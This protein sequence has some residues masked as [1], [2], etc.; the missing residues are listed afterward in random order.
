[1]IDIKNLTKKFGGF[2]AISDINFQ[3][4]PCSVCGLIG[5]NGA[6]KTTLLKNAAGIYKPDSGDVLIDGY[7]V[8]DNGEIRQKLFYIPDDLYFPMNTSVKAMEKF[9]AGYYPTF[10]HGIFD[11]LLDVFKLNKAARVRSFSKGM[12]RQ[13]EIALGLSVNVTNLLLDESFD[14]LDPEKRHITKK[15]LLE[16]MAERECAMIIS[17]H[18]L[19]EITDLCDHVILLDGQKVKMDVKTNEL[20][21]KYAAFK[22]IFSSE[23]DK[24]VLEAIG[25]KHIKVQKQ[26]ASFTVYGDLKE[27]RL[28]IEKM[29][30]LNIE[31]FSLSLE[32]IFL[33]E[34]EEREYETKSFFSQDKAV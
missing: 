24:D 10:N 23:P 34:M 13:L 8:F 6:G 2:T 17:S 22:V 32:E 11:K 14:G 30:P 12:Q 5:Y 27:A 33:S 1:M 3:V 25:C 29:N 9:Y 20:Q 16:Y 4:E 31:Q 28:K 18:N 21:D 19:N 7:K 26:I 15:L